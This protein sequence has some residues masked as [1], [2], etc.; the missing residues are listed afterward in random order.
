[1]L[2]L[3]HCYSPSEP[4]TRNSVATVYWRGPGGFPSGQ[5]TAGWLPRQN[6]QTWVWQHR[7]NVQ[8]FQFHRQ[9][10]SPEGCHAGLDGGSCLT[11]GSRVCGLDC[12][13]VGGWPS[14]AHSVVLW[15]VAMQRSHLEADLVAPVKYTAYNVELISEHL[16]LPDKATR[17]LK[18]AS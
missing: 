13:S 3:S 12:E 17:C 11:A 2:Y 5:A 14:S 4:V 8:L 7:W 1:M 16:V 10:I 9:Q 18:A 15:E 6:T